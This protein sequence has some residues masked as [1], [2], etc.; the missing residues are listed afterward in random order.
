MVPKL[1][2]QTET[3]ISTMKCAIG[4]GSQLNLRRT[5][6]KMNKP[7]EKVEISKAEYEELLE[8]QELLRALQYGGV[9]NWEWYEA[10]IED[11]QASQDE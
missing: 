4:L 1:K 9:D 6:K 3:A 10:S 8:A 2:G 11:Y 5:K 7:V